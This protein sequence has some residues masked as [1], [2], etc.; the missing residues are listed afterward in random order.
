MNRDPQGKAIVADM[1]NGGDTSA[2][3]VSVASIDS[4]RVDGVAASKVA[5]AK[6]GKVT[7]TIV[8]RKEI[9]VPIAGLRGKGYPAPVNQQSGGKQ[10]AGSTATAKATP[11]K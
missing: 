10:T 6:K 4:G 9:S 11:R 3:T 8:G 7:H 2:A 1:E 5:G